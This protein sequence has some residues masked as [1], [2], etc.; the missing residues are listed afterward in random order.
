M[1]KRA[2]L[3]VDDFPYT[4]ELFARYGYFRDSWMRDRFLRI[5]DTCTRYT[6]VP[7]FM[8]SSHALSRDG[9]LVRFDE[10]MPATLLAMT[11]AFRDGLINVNAHGMLHLDPETY[12]ATGNVDSQEFS[13]L[14]EHDTY[15]HLNN[16]CVFIMEVF[17][18]KAN[19]FVAPAWGYN[20]LVTKRVASQFFLYIAD[21]YDRWLRGM[22]LDF[23]AIDPEFGFV[24]FPETWRYGSYSR[25]TSI[26]NYWRHRL[27]DFRTLHLMQHGHRVPGTWK[28]GLSVN[29][30]KMASHALWG[31]LS[32]ILKTAQS[33]GFEWHTLE[34]TAHRILGVRSNSATA[35]GTLT[36]PVQTKTPKS[37]QGAPLPTKKSESHLQ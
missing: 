28:L 2:Y 20:E 1:G 17:G 30:F 3:R 37:P 21:S 13:S 22:C 8:V 18:K 5:L 34:A 24:H 14:S 7:E 32:G 36:A 26:T 25:A 35:S 6:V 9:T 11:E 33:H 27:A 12:L 10:V 29:P 16:V 23:G 15:D 4:G 19:G 31:N